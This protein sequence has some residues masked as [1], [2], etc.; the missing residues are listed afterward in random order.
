[1]GGFVVVGIGGTYI[2]TFIW[3]WALFHRIL[4]DPAIGA[5]ASVGAAFSTSVVIM[6][7]MG[8]L[9]GIGFLLTMFG[10]MLLAAYLYQKGLR[11]RARMAESDI[12]DV[13][14]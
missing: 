12:A 11:S 3:E 14:E 7:L 2:L 9:T 1:M 6:F 5:L 10:A 13:F 4:D 8:A